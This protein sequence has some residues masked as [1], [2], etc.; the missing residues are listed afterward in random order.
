MLGC[1][2]DERGSPDH[3]TKHHER[4]PTHIVQ[5]NV[6]TKKIWCYGCTR[7]VPNG[8]AATASSSSNIQTLLSA[9]AAS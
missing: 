9:P 5:L 8:L 2:D 4:N 6:R 1:S 7:E 3:S